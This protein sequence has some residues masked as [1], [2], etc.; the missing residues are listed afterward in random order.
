MIDKINRLLFKLNSQ[1]QLLLLTLIL[2]VLI[3]SIVNKGTHNLQ[4]WDESRNGVNA[5]EMLHNNDCIN[6]YYNNKLDTW[7]AK[8]P[9]MIWLIAASYKVFGFNEFA[10]RFPSTIAAFLFFIIC[11]YTVLLLDTTLTAFLTCMILIA[12]KAIF[13]NHIGL[14]GDFDA[15]LLFF[16]TA[17]VYS[18][19]LYIERG[20]K[21]A[22][23]FTALFVG[24]AFYTKGPA[25]FVLIPG[26]ALYLTFK[27]KI[28]AIIKDK[29]F[30][31]ATLLMSTIVA[32]WFML[33]LIYGK[34]SNQSVYGSKNSIETMLIH[35]TFRRLTASD[36]EP[37]GTN[38]HSPFFFFQVLDSRLNLWNYLFY[39]VLA[40]GIFFSIQK[41]NFI[42]F[43]S[44]KSSRFILLSFCLITPLT[45]ILSLSANQH[46]WY[47]APIFMFIAFITAKGLCMI[48]KK[49]NWTYIV[50][51]FLL[52]FTLSRHVH[53]IYS[54]DT[55]VHEAL[56][57]NKFLKNKRLF[58]VSPLRQDILLYLKWLN[59]SIFRTED[60][61]QSFHP[62]DLILSSEQ[63][64]GLSSLQEFEG[65]YLGIKN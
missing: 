55:D 11:F 10:L 59:V 38:G 3:L 45:L 28:I 49:W 20:K 4:E 32:S 61:S 26:F 12:T 37:N 54:L 53:Y 9:L 52:L 25:A 58:V 39:F 35:D 15:L 63:L 17:S 22:I 24:L 57:E 14:T 44:E 48:G 40:V 18:F 51:I 16:L 19:I 34:T 47:L 29:N 31:F 36:F 43:L 21:S 23:Y 41:K 33:V 42:K 8:P 30:W 60:P 62:G 5:Y 1:K 46:N 27:K 2:L 6:L 50:G 64:P 13:G 56:T 7:N 65:Y